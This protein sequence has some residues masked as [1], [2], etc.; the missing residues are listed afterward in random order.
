[1]LKLKSFGVTAV[2]AVALAAPATSAAQGQDL[3]NPDRQFPTAP[4]QTQDLRNADNRVAGPTS[5]LAGTVSPAKP[6]QDLR[7]ADRRAPGAGEIE[8]VPVQVPATTTI[9]LPAEGFDW[10]D[11]GIGAAGGIALLAMLAGV[12]TAATHRRRGRVT[13]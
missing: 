13:A 8:V 4:E 12:A 6:T 5:S 10:G 9:A 7:N 11:A 1:V 2:L 3:R